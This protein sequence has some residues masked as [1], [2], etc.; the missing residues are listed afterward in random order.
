VI[1]VN[2][3]DIASMGGD[4]RWALVS[5]ALP[6]EIPVDFVDELYRGMVEEASK[7]GA[8][9]V[10]GNVSRARE[11]VAIDLFLTGEAPPGLLVLRSGAREGDAVLVTGA[12]GDSRA[13][14]E[15]ITRPNL[16]VSAESSRR[17]LEKHLTPTPRLREGKLLAESGRVH[18]MCD[19]SDGIVSDLGHICRA[20]GKGAEI[21]A[22]LA[23]VSSACAEV[24]RAAGRDPLD[25]VLR[26]GEDYELLFTASQEEAPRLRALLQNE[27]NTPCH[28]LGR[29]TCGDA[30]VRVLFPEGAGAGSGARGSGGW[31]HFGPTPGT[32]SGFED[33]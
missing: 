8:A 21:D 6:P 17:V 24:A 16:P 28:T 3:S 18:A 15:L 29:I 27:L 33:P 2:V 1:A 13:G 14:F 9:I 23:P 10:G 4:P 20:S 25:W 26:G 12:P 31:D 22:A 32:P 5:L 30:E 19:V 7:A 11:G